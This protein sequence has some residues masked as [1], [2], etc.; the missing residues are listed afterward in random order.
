MPLDADDEIVGVEEYVLKKCYQPEADDNE[1]C[2]NFPIALQ[3]GG[4]WIGWHCEGSPVI[5]LFGILFWK[6]IFA[7]IPN[8][9][10]SPYQDAPL[11]LKF[12]DFFHNR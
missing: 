8:V 2:P 7:N 4:G 5:T 3:G 10:L 9:F 11:D 6:V 1:T 12:L